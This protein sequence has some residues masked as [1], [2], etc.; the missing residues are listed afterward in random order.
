MAV[1]SCAQ[2]EYPGSQSEKLSADVVGAVSVGPLGWDDVGR[3]DRTR[4]YLFDAKGEVVSRLD[5]AAIAN[6]RLLVSPQRVVTAAGNTVTALDHTGRFTAPIDPETIVKAA[7]NNPDTGA[8]TIWFHRALETRYASIGPD[9]TSRTGLVPGT[10]GIVGYCGD[11][12]FAVVGDSSTRTRQR[13]YEI[14]F[15][16]DPVVVGEWHHDPEFQPISWATCTG[17]GYLLALYAPEGTTATD[18]GGPN[19]TLVSID[20][21][22]GSRTETRLDLLD[23]SWRTGSGTLTVVGDRLYWITH[24]NDVLS[25]ALDGSSTV[26]KEWSLPGLGDETSVSVEGTTVSAITHREVPTFTQYDLRTG[27]I[28]REPVALPWLES[29]QGVVS[30]SGGTI[31]TIDASAGMVG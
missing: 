8:A 7:A 27:R 6:N 2:R 9:R 23:D 19:P 4:V 21:T 24:E 22:D 16:G 31:Y 5:G 20:T 14:P 1:A 30:D 25:V 29:I 17:R 15:D 10:V 26:R 3:K 28:T 18:K 12:H 13:L 11:K